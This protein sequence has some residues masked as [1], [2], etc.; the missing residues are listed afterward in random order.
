[1]FLLRQSSPSPPLCGFEHV[2]STL[3]GSVRAL[4]SVVHPTASCYYPGDL[5]VSIHQMGGLAETPFPVLKF[6][7]VMIGLGQCGLIQGEE[8]FRVR[9]VV[10]AV[11]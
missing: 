9:R 6:C 10:W 11:L 8:G 7:E 2:S 3:W 4:R 5:S 1:M